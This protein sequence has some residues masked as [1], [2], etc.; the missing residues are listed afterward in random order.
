M[1]KRR[2]NKKVCF[3][4][5]LESDLR[6]N[7]LKNN[8]TCKHTAPTL[9]IIYIWMTQACSKKFEIVEIRTQG[10]WIDTYIASV[11]KI[12]KMQYLGRLSPFLPVQLSS[13]Y[14]Q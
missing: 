12:Q 2:L 8:A 3:G 7:E 5:M 14:L 10:Q 6:V 4:D 11:T 13:V 1:R 9:Q